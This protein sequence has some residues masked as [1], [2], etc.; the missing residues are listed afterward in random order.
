MVITVVGMGFV[1]LTA[2]VGFAA[3]GHQVYGIE[4]DEDGEYVMNNQPKE[5]EHGEELEIG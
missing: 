3:K 1:G 4:K 5:K 2:A